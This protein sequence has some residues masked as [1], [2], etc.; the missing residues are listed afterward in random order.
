[1]NKISGSCHCRSAQWEFSLPIKTVVKCHCGN[2]RKM[3]SADYSSWI[4]LPAEQFKLTVG[5]DHI[6]NYQVNEVSSKNFCSKCG[7]AT[8]LINGKHFPDNFVLPLGAVD[9]YSDE[10]APQIQMY[11]PDKAS[12][13]N[14]HE[15][16]PV[17]S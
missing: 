9:N 16:E 7:S 6:T 1:M 13:I 8:H 2:C 3:Q 14:I 4:I 10:L 17:F 5:K 15:D 11:T 12:W